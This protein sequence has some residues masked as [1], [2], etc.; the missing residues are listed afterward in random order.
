MTPASSP[1]SATLPAS[2]DKNWAAFVPQLL[3]GSFPASFQ[4]FGPL[5]KDVIGEGPV[6][7]KGGVFGEAVFNFKEA[8]VYGGVGLF[9]HQRMVDCTPPSW[10][11]PA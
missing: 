7:D 3:L 10:M 2:T 6:V 5:L 9:I 11:V 1:A 8:V 4:V